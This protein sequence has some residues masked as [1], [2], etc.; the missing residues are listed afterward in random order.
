MSENIEFISAAEL[1]TT[2]ATEVDVLCIENG[3]LKKKS[4]A[5]LGG[6]GADNYDAIIHWVEEDNDGDGTRM[7]TFE[8]G[9]YEA[10]KKINDS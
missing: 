5:N 3:E 6:G 2:E 9:S 4:G 10:M 1:P 7:I 8:S